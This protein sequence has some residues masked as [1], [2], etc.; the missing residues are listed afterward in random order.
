MF[1]SK[2]HLTLML[3]IA[4][5]VISVI[6]YIPYHIFLNTASVA[7]EVIYLLISG[8]VDLLLPVIFAAVL[9]VKSTEKRRVTL[10]TALALSVGR[11]AF[12]APYFYMELFALGMELTGAVLLSLLIGLLLSLCFGAFTLLLYAVSLCAYKKRCKGFKKG[13]VPSLSSTLED[14][15]VFDFSRG[16][17]AV[18]S[19]S[20]I[21]A[22]VLSLP[23]VRTVEF[24]V[25]Y[26]ESF[27]FTEILSII[28]EVVY[29]LVLYILAQVAVTKFVGA[30]VSED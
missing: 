11:I 13:K 10:L 19:P 23:F 25:N 26:G 5:L 15:G 8:A 9:L 20:V 24:F 27:V 14:G 22:F 18:L 29:A 4:C 2:K 1:F 12:Y 30:I 17:V 21:I 7:A 28:I 6:E 16:R 3:S